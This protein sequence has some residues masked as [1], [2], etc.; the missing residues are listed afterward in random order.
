MAAVQLRSVELSESG[1]R[2]GSCW[3]CQ[4]LTSWSTTTLQWLLTFYEMEHPLPPLSCLNMR[5]LKLDIIA[6]CA[7]NTRVYASTL[8][9]DS[10]NFCTVDFSD[11]VCHWSNYAPCVLSHT[12]DLRC[13]M[14]ILC[15]PEVHTDLQQKEKKHVEEVQDAKRVDQEGHRF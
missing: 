9:I 5:M 11:V 13:M 6:P 7:S 1:T 4:H 12:L 2:S 3:V 15:V 8:R 10:V 14:F